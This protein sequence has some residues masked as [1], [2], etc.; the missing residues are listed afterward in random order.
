MAWLGRIGKR[1][2]AR[3]SVLAPV[4]PHASTI[5]ADP[6]SFQASHRRL[7]WML[8]LSAGTNIVLGAGVVVLVQTIGH[9]VPLKETEIA[10]IRTYGPVSYTHLTL[11]T[12][13]LV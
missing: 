7:A 8:R 6:Y 10:L 9:L 3:T 4:S 5:A 11:P 13:D 12:S 1:D 2:H